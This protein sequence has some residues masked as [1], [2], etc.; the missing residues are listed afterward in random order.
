MHDRFILLKRTADLTDQEALLLSA[1]VKNYPVLG[2]VHQTK[3]AFFGLYAATSRAQAEQRFVAWE[4]ALSGEIREAFGEVL[5][6]WKHWQGEI[7]AY[8]AHPVTN[9]YTES[10]N[11]LI[12]ATDRMDRGYSFE[13]LRAKMLWAEGPIEKVPRRPKL[14]RQSMTPSRTAGLL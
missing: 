4:Q 10:L 6:A 7:L 13:V 12:R 1:W 3:E 2:A 8:F 14:T 11:S 9:G 5:T